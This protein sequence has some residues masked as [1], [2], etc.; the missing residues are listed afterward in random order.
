MTILETLNNEL[1]KIFDKLGL[2]KKYAFFQYSDRPDLS[3]FQTNCA[4]PLCK[5]LKKSPIDV[6]NLIIP[7]LKKINLFKDVSVAGAGFINVILSDEILLK[8]L[9]STFDEKNC[10][11]KNTEKQK[12]V[13]I[14]FSSPNVAKEMHVGHLRSTVIGESLRRIFI[15]AGDKVIADNHLGDWGTNMGMVIEGI[16]LQYPN[17]KCF[18]E[19]FNED[20]IDDLNL[21]PADLLNIYKTAN[22]KAKEDEEFAKKVRE[23]TKNLQDGYKPYRTLWQYFWKVSIDDM[24]EIYK[25]LDTHFDLWN[26]ESSVH[27]LIRKMII[28]LEKEGFITVSQGAKIID[29]SEIDLPPALIEKSDGAVMYASSDLATILDRKEKFNP[30]LML[31]VVDYRQ[32][33]HFQQVFA[34][35]KKVGYLDKNHIAEHI[36]F[37]TMN[38]QDG[39]PFKTR[40][41]DV[42]KLRELIDEMVEVISKKSQIKDKETI[43]KIAVACLKFADLIN[44]RETSYIFD[45]EQ[46][47]NFEGKT[48][49]Y[50]LYSL[51]RINSI[52]NNCEKFN[53]EIT[54]IKTKEEK[55]LLIELTRFNHIFKATYEKKAPNYLAEYVY[56]LS[57]KFSVFYSACPINTEK[58][59]NY[60]KSKISLLYLSKKYIETSLYLLGINSV[61]KM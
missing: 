28:D 57:K 2:D 7:E 3:D 13:I 47:T 23:T 53:Y 42:V 12:T 34:S 21:K 4:M 59:E 8:N 31:Y 25:V 61:E 16:R 35:A 32:S 36:A 51:V 26:G 49:A 44:Y 54:E 37:G 11:Y 58:D 1:I 27:D 39:K 52:L 19:G 56:N 55:E 22:G 43:E 29:L 38:G 46:F 17:I 15:F 33:L 30:D 41:G 40:A 50:I 18:K 24:K 6:A 14:D 20:K 60:K 45:M 48:G 9:N 10:G 5:I